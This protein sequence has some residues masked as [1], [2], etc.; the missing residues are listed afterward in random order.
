MAAKK[1]ALVTGAG[2]GVGRAAALALMKEGYAVVLAGRRIEMLE[3]VAAEGAQTP[4]ESLTVSADV[5]DPAAIK[6][7]FAK[8]K[9]TYGRL[10]LL[11]N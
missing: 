9:D 10:D 5:G 2:T 6:A 1:V 11:F 7:M 4:G 8:I 3:A